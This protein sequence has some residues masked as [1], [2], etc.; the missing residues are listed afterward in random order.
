MEIPNVQQVVSA[1]SGTNSM[2]VE[3]SGFNKLI[4]IPSGNYEILVIADVLNSPVDPN[5]R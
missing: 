1:S 5:R 3:H 2:V 4:S